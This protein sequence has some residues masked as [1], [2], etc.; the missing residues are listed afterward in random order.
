MGIES[1]G[2]YNDFESLTNGLYNLFRDIAKSKIVEEEEGSVLY[3]TKRDKS[4][5]SSKDQVLSLSKLKTIE[6]RVFRKMREKLR[7]FYRNKKDSKASDSMVNA[8]RREME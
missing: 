5:N 7:N 8:F 4:G 6:Y 2:L 3:L 1:V